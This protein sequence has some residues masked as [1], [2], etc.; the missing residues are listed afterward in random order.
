M[1]AVER[2][3]SYI[4]RGVYTVSGPFHPFGGAVDIIVVQ[5]QDGSFKSNPWY[6][7]FGKFQGVLKTKEKV[8]NISVNGTD[9]SFH[10]YLDHKGEAYFLREVDADVG[11]SIFSPLSSGDE[12]DEQ[13]HSGGLAKTQSLDF[14]GNRSNLVTQI[15]MGNGKIV[16]RTNSGRSR[17]FGLVFGGKPMKEDNS[18]RKG[19]TNVQRISSLERAEIAADLLEVNWS[20]NLSTTNRKMSNAAVVSAPDLR[21]E[22]AKV[23]AEINDKKGMDGSSVQD[24]IID[25]SVSM[26]DLDEIIGSRNETMGDNFGTGVVDMQYSEEIASPSHPCLRNHEEVL[27]ISELETSDTAGT[28]EITFEQS[29]AEI[30]EENAGSDEMVKG[31]ISETTVTDL[32]GPSLADVVVDPIVH[33]SV[34]EQPDAEQA[35]DKQGGLVATGVSIEFSGENRVSS[36][37][38]CETSESLNVR[39]V[40]SSAQA[41]DTPGGACEEVEIHSDVLYETTELISEVNSQPESGVFIGND[42]SDGCNPCNLELSNDRHPLEWH[43]SELGSESEGISENSTTN[44]I[45]SEPSATDGGKVPKETLSSLDMHLINSNSVG[46]EVLGVV[47]QD[48]V[49]EAHTPE[50]TLGADIVEICENQMPMEDFS[51]RLFSD[52]EMENRDEKLVNPSMLSPETLEE[53][54]FLFI[55]TDN[56][57]ATGP[58]Y[59]ESISADVLEM[60]NHSMEGIEEE[61][62]SGDINHESSFSSHQSFASQSFPTTG[63]YSVELVQDSSPNDFKGLP[64]SSRS[65]ASPISIPTGRTQA[66]PISIPTGRIRTGGVSQLFGSMPSMR[67]H[68]RDLE[69]SDILRPHSLD[70]SSENSI[71]GMLRKDFSSKLE[72]RWAPESNLVPDQSTSEAAAAVVAT[73]SSKEY[74]QSSTYPTVEISLCRHLLFEGMGAQAASQVFDSEKVDLDKFTALGPS[75][76]KN[77][78]LVVRIGGRYLPWDAAAPTILGMVSF[79]QDQIFEPEGSIAVDQVGKTLEGEL[80]GAIVPSGGSWKLWPFSFR[81]SK[82]MRPI[83]SSPRGTKKVDADNTSQSASEGTGGKNVPKTRPTKKVRS[84]VPTSE[85]LASLNLKDGRNVITFTFSTAVLGTQKVDAR[86]YLWKWNTRI[87][88]SDVDGTITKS[89]VLGQFMP[90]VGKDWSQTGVAHLFSAIKEN[91]YQLLF[92]SAR[93][94]AQAYLTRQFLFNL[95]QDGKALPDGPVA[96]SPDGLFPSLYREGRTNGL[97][98]GHYPVSRA[99]FLLLEE[100]LMSSRSHV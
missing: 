2:L 39:I 52:N 92:L 37:I 54:Q 71:W 12:T 42:S 68:I 97:G 18:L 41:L 20:T 25:H 40:F 23:D 26:P 19:D 75:L 3:S 10:M 1:Y 6:V 53:D 100:L 47:H 64:D 33:S 49:V 70:L 73:Q 4:S 90:L 62:V 69:R 74:E 58:Q 34:V 30:N 66:S 86:I 91:G 8:V 43:N 24:S 88:V 82:T 16:T 94:I 50:N 60:D 31:S 63:S 98:I 45:K 95:K 13:S 5:Q 55:D 29:T 93:A 36:C 15:D 61:H 76:V 48:T 17:I 67:G 51:S 38:Y 14:D 11:E 78:R 65:Q 81:K 56:F 28:R 72:S 44:S 96:I 85:Q 79:S 32:Q 7:R 9:A 35:S 46:A 21:T 84:L 27:E 80:S 22:E 87:V 83:P 57:V 99:F 77:D 59:E 89:D